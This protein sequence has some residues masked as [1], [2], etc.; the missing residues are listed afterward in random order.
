VSAAGGKAEPG[1]V[2]EAEHGDNGGQLTVTFFGKYRA[3]LS[4]TALET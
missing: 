4:F 3:K 2:L 1:I